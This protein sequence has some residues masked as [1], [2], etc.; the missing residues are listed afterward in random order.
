MDVTIDAALALTPA[1]DRLALAVEDA[2]AF[3]DVPLACSGGAAA[4]TGDTAAMTGAAPPSH[5]GRRPPAS[6]LAPERER[7]RRTSGIAGVPP[8]P[9]EL[10]PFTGDEIR[11]LLRGGEVEA[12]L[13]ERLLATAARLRGGL[14]LALAEGLA[15]LRRGDRLA[16]LGC[17]LDDYAREALDL[18]KRCAEGLA[19]LG[20][21][22]RAR[23]LLRE[24]L[25][26]GKVRL[27]AAETV[28]PVA[29]GEAEAGWVE[30][31]A[32]WTV[33]EL[34]A[35]VRAASARA[36]GRA[37]DGEP[38]DDWVE[39]RTQLPPEERLVL[40]EAL[41]LAGEQLPGST[42]AERLEALAQEYLAEYSTDADADASRSLGPGFRDRRPRRRRDTDRDGWME[43]P[44]LV[45]LRAPDLR[46]DGSTPTREL[47]ARLRE[48]AR[49]RGEWDRVVG[50]CGHG[51]KR[52]GMH[53]LL[54]YGSFRQYVEERLGLPARAVEQRVALEERLAGSPA[55]REALGQGVSY[56]KLRLLARLP[57]G[58]IAAWI[59]R[60]VEATCVAL[61]RAVDSERERQ[62]RARRRLA[63]PLTRRV[64]VLLAAAV[65]Q[66]RRRHGHALATGTCLAI[67]AFHFLATWSG[68]PRRARTLSRRIRERDEGW[69][70]APGCSRR[71]TH[72]HH[73]DYRS[74]GGSDDPENQVGVCAFH[75]LRCIHGG[76]LT[77]DGR[78]PD[79]LTWRLGGRV[80]RGP[81]P[82][83]PGTAPSVT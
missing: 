15:E 5:P 80:W 43:L 53:L 20:G 60:A 71:A 33:R 69:C 83:R 68:G 79:A 61:R 75:H 38:D 8:P 35:A 3:A 6:R 12:D 42:R 65:A 72:A 21:G 34:E 39:L 29:V 23:P 11:L 2:A 44:P 77:V 10:P 36:R 26:A 59:P 28:L 58:E 46:L 32:S 63:T 66:A 49:L 4:V 67:V 81:R 51:V 45:E 16:A 22:L 27:R 14:D 24:A 41:A 19:R 18:G 54:G 64:A 55:L 76:F 62:L 74:H 40:D 30:R 57:E 1:G 37:A 52:S 70:Q 50:W 56:E 48:L 25:R 78:A 31:A 73:I 7:T 13:C 82:L 9:A 47:D 17:H